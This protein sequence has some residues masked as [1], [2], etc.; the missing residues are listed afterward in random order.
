MA[1]TVHYE[2]TI[3]D[4]F[5]CEI[6]MPN[7]MQC[8]SR[9]QFKLTAKNSDNSDRV[10]FRCSHHFNLA[11]IKAKENNIEYVDDNDNSDIVGGNLEPHQQDP[12]NA[13][14]Q[15]LKAR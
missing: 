2:R 10:F 9:A 14:T 7:Q 12:N 13:Q 11:L 6:L 15:A 3:A 5:R 1:E 8:P 4:G